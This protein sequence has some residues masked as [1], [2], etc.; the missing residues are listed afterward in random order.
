VKYTDVGD[1]EGDICPL[2]VVMVLGD[3]DNKAVLVSVLV[4]ETFTNDWTPGVWKP[5]TANAAVATVVTADRV[6]R[7][8]FSDRLR[9][10]SSQIVVDIEFIL[11]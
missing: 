7:W 1:S 2:E 8:R 3:N 10:F 11:V 6:I 5:N 4:V 9:G